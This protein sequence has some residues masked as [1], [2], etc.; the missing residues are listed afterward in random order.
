[1]LHSAAVNHRVDPGRAAEV[2]PLT[3]MSVGLSSARVRSAEQILTGVRQGQPLGVLLGYQLE[4][5]LQDSGHGDYVAPFRLLA[6]L[7]PPSDPSDPRAVAAV[8]TDVVD[9]LGL[10]RLRQGTVGIPWGT[11]VGPHELGPLTAD[12]RAALDALDDS[13][14]AVSDTLLAEGVHA[15]VTGNSAAARAT[16]DAAARGDLVAPEPSFVRT[17][18]TGLDLTHR[19]IS[20]APSVSSTWPTTP[21][22]ADAPALSAWAAAAMGPLTDIDVA[23]QPVD[24]T[25]GAD[26]ATSAILVPLASLS[27]GPLDLVRLAGQQRELS[28]YVRWWAARDPSRVPGLP[29]GA[30]VR[31]G[32]TDVSRPGRSA[33]GPLLMTA[34]A[35]GIVLGQSRGLDQR[36]LSEPGTTDPA[37]DVTELGS[38]V[39]AARLRLLDLADALSGVVGPN[40]L[41]T[42]FWHGIPGVLATDPADPAAMAA[43]AV[44]ARDAVAAR[45]VAATLPAP[46]QASGETPARALARLVDTMQGLRGDRWPVLPDL[47]APFA[48]I[49]AAVRA[50]SVSTAPPG[51]EPASWLARIARVSAPVA[52]LETLCGCSELLGGALPL[53]VAVGQ[54]PLPPAGSGPTPWAGLPL[55]ARTAAERAA[56]RTR[57]SLAFVGAAPEDAPARLSGLVV[58]EWAET[59]P[60]T[61]ETAG[62]SFHFETPQAQA[63]QA[64]LVVAPTGGTQ[65][66]WVLS[67]LSGAVFDALELATARLAEL[68]DLPPSPILPALYLD[69][70]GP[71]ADP[72]QAANGVPAGRLFPPPSGFGVADS[73]GGPVISRVSGVLVQGAASQLQVVGSDLAALYTIAIIGLTIEVLTHSPT[74]ATLAVSVPAGAPVGPAELVASTDLGRAIAQVQVNAQPRLASVV[75]AQ[76]LAQALTQVTCS[77]TITGQA[78]G[79]VTGATVTT[80][81]GARTGLSAAVTA[82]DRPDGVNV[83]LVLT[84][85]VPGSPRPPD[86][87]DPS[88]PGS[89]LKPPRPP[90][91]T[92]GELALAISLVTS[93]GSYS[94]AGLSP[95]LRLTTLDWEQP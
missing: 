44:T 19:I 8:A 47:A 59:V 74:G 80:V 91:A 23:V 20:L 82:V 86:D 14:D 7:D 71:D 10:S 66:T 57:V 42:A 39:D 72:S 12:V 21:N 2:G 60:N 76:P 84:V 32:P 25:T 9:G 78:L 92:H 53:S 63:P 85:T 1:M 41:E 90:R 35:A 77:V 13:I 31:L 16:F 40:E 56:V 28:A 33:L 49:A 69:G 55:A 18:R 24:T 94:T 37:I 93:N 70:V 67:D 45:L 64:V 22:A 68:A 89:P 50:T 51:Q 30:T 65:P 38:R 5:Q 43:A 27:I 34:R 87:W 52:A 36:D 48:P 4:R 62:L 11:M 81:A 17:P 6:P 75:T 29:A 58:D 3:P 88:Q 54:L 83:S 95:G 73:T 61:S 15:V 79:D 26:L 46:A